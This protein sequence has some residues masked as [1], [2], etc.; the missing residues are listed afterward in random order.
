[1]DKLKKV[2]NI[3]RYTKKKQFIKSFRNSFKN[4]SHIICSYFLNFITT[5]SSFYILYYPEMIGL[6]EKNGNDKKTSN[7]IYFNKM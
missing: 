6:L 5:V 1:M 4:F 2:L 3:Y 7:Y